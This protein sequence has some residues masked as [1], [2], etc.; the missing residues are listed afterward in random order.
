MYLGMAV[1][2]WGNTVCRARGQDLFSFQATILSTSILITGLEKT[3][4]AA[5]AVVIGSVR[6]HVDEVFFTHHGFD[7]K[8]EVF[9]HRVAEGFA[10]QLAGVLNR[11][12]DFQV[13]V[14][15]GINLEFSFPDPL[16]II[17][18]DAFDFKIIGNL[19]LLRSEPDRE[20]FVP[21]LRIEPD[22]TFQV[23]HGLYFQADNFFPVGVIG[24]EEAVVFSRP[25]FGAVCPV[26]AH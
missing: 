19:E 8:P 15:V 3:A 5:A 9:G 23:L 20:E 11:E 1:M 18:N 6:G 7:H 14:P 4:A 13:F 26:R 25:P 21:S 2:A 12:F 16:G 17:L 22:L 24:Q 10:H